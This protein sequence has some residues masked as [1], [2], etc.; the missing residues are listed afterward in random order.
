VGD[1]VFLEHVGE[2]FGAG[3]FAIVAKH[4]RPPTSLSFVRIWARQ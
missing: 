2:A 4:V 3:H 1:A